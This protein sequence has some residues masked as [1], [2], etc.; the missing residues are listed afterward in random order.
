MDSLVSW[1]RE[2]LLSG[3]ILLMMAM[4]I[5]I[6]LLELV[7]PARPVPARHYAFN[8]A[9]S[10][11]NYAIQT[12]LQPLIA[13]AMAALVR[14]VGVGLIDLQAIGVGGAVLAMLVSAVVFDFFFYW[15]HRLEHSNP[16][17]WQE[18]LVHHS[19]QSMNVTSGSRS[20][21]L[22]AILVP[23]FI[24]VPTAVLFK[25]PPV[26]IGLLALVPFAW[27][28]FVHANLKLGFGPLW[29]LLVSPSYHRIHHSLEKQ[30]IDKNFATWFPVWDILF[31]TAVQ[32][33]RGEY[34][35]TGVAGVSIQGLWHGLAF[36]FIGWIAMIRGGRTA[37]SAQ[38]TARPPYRRRRSA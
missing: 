11:A 35:A 24:S 30:H 31:G 10:F 6:G 18:H 1:L 15:M 2:F 23:I 14:K 17:L 28:Y 7:M 22:D 16:V 29:W 38:P 26:T 37:A 27:T 21:F 33:T 32:P 20:H 4:F 13:G 36:P 5:G 25:L 12:A 9:Y 8:L 19:D 34:P 3:P